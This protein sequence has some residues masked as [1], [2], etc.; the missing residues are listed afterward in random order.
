MAQLTLRS[1]HWDN[2]FSILKVE[3]LEH[4]ILFYFPQTMFSQFQ[5]ISWSDVP[6]GRTTIQ[7]L[8]VSRYFLSFFHLFTLV[9][10]YFQNVIE[11]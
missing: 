10:L 9:C 8:E 5:Q 6:D 4:R 11:Y 2:C 3:V 1:Q 7:L